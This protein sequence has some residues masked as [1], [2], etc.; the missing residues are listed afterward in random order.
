MI[1][2]DQHNASYLAV[3][4]HY[5]QIYD[6]PRIKE[7]T[8][9]MSEALKNVVI[10]LLLSPFDS[11]QQQILHGLST[12]KNLQKLS[13]YKWEKTWVSFILKF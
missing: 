9:H 8:T 1:K 5:K 3:C 7:N 11:E 6:T 2:L 10:Y 4:K 12:D 13:K